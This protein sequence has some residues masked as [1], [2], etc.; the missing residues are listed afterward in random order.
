MEMGGMKAEEQFSKELLKK[1]KKF[2]E[3]S[4]MINM[5]MLEILRMM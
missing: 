4:G 1:I 5:N 2:K 3:R